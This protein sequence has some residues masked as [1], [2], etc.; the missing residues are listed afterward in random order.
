M[1][2]ILT[3]TQ[4]LLEANILTFRQYSVGD[5]LLIQEKASGEHKFAT[6][7]GFDKNSVSELVL[8]LN[9]VG[10]QLPWHIHPRNT[11]YEITQI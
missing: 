10:A 9:V 5:K 6:V 4:A 2:D 7:M 3:P 1:Q 8:V 11:C